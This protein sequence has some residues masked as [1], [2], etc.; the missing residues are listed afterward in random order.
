MA[1]IVSSPYAIPDGTLGFLWQK[2]R[3]PVDKRLDLRSHKKEIMK[4]FTA[5]ALVLGLLFWGLRIINILIFWY[6]GNSSP[7][8]LSLGEGLD[9]TL[10]A[11]DVTRVSEFVASLSGGQ[12]K[13]KLNKFVSRKQ[14][15]KQ[16]SIIVAEALATEYTNYIKNDPK[17]RKIHCSF[18][19]IVHCTFSFR[20]LSSRTRRWSWRKVRT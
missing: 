17:V 7:L 13:N 1:T 5:P 19:Y 9:V 8:V 20:S 16:D 2:Y 15:S 14:L 4:G 3:G 11:D 18:C 12:V 6:V 10:D